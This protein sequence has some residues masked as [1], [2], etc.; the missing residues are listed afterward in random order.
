MARP[1]G[2]EKSD[3]LVKAMNCFWSKGYHGTSMKDLVE[4]TGL[5]RGSMYSEFNDK[6]DLYLQA[7]S[8]YRDEHFLPAIR[9]MHDQPDWQ[10]R[11]ISL[12]SSAAACSEN[13]NPLGCFIA[14]CLADQTGSNPNINK[15]MSETLYLIE[16]HL[17]TLLSTHRGGDH[18]ALA[19]L[20]LSILMGRKLLQRHPDFNQMLPLKEVLT[21]LLKA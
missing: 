3:V 2:F 11:L 12:L 5:N 17:N 10:D 20:I 19:N 13:E 8:F 7:L 21:P 14:N 4:A 9:E 18:K 16:L 15:I 1:K 6:E